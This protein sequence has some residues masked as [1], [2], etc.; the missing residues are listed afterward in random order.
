MTF[1]HFN[2]VSSALYLSQKPEQHCNFPHIWKNCSFLSIIRTSKHNLKQFKNKNTFYTLTNSKEFVQSQN[3]NGI[4]LACQ[5][6]IYPNWGW[7]MIQVKGMRLSLVTKKQTNK[8]KQFAVIFITQVRM[9]VG[10]FD[11]PWQ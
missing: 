7:G 3:T 2:K 6:C 8:Q 4:Y 9:Q 10:K 5:Y 1:I 11:S